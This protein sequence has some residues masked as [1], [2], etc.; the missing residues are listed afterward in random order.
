L[1]ENGG[2][3]LNQLF[4]K[5]TAGEIIGNLVV[6]IPR[7]ISN[8]E[9]KILFD[10]FEKSPEV[11]GVAIFEA[12]D[13]KGLV[14]RNHFYRE[15][16]K[17][18]G[19]ALYMGRPVAMLMDTAPMIVDYDT[20]MSK[21]GIMAM[22]RPK[23]NLYDHVL[24]KKDKQFVGAVGI[25]PLLSE[26]SRQSEE[27][28]MVLK[29]QNEALKK[30]NE[31]EI[32]LT[33]TILEKNSLLE[34]KSNSIKNLLD[35]AGQ[36]FL[37]FSSD[38]L[39]EEDYS[40][41]CE[42]IIERSLRNVSYLELISL[43]FEERMVAVQQ[44]ALQR[45]FDSSS[46]I[47]DEAYLSLLPNECEIGEKT[48]RLDYK[49]IEF[50]GEKKLMVV[51]T[52]ISEKVALERSMEEERQNQRLIVKALTNSGDINN[53]F[54]ELKEFFETGIRLTLANN[55]VGEEVFNEIFRQVH[56]FKG[57]FAQFGLHNTSGKLHIL[58]DKLQRL[59]ENKQQTRQ[60]ITE[61]LAGVTTEELLSKDKE[62]LTNILGEDFLQK[63][64]K[65]SVSPDAVTELA[66]LVQKVCPEDQC[67]AILPYINKLKCINMK[68]L[69]SQYEDY[70]RYLAERLA[71]PMPNFTV[72]G[73][74]VWIEKE[75]Y[76]N[77]FKSSVH[78]FRNICDHGIEYPEERAERQKNL[79]GNI[80]CHISDNGCGN[81]LIEISDD[82]QGIDPAVI[83][84][85]ALESGLF[86]EED[87]AHWREEEI[88]NLVFTQGF[89]TKSKVDTLS[90]RGVGMAAVK[91]AVEQL[92]G[93]I[94]LKSCPGIGTSYLI[95]IPK[96]REEVLV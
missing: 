20:E 15:I 52:D 94:S 28:V 83:R 66:A 39:I 18:F 73:D 38:F 33:K 25:S 92:N 42:K 51:L 85:K 17:Q 89:S 61:V 24:V 10:L 80:T 1:F 4:K 32:A 67:K 43:L 31:Q 45:Y 81:I 40:L 96:N 22:S 82:G 63:N 95:I 34:K 71:K 41:E 21:V 87:L 50:L 77:L 62:V 59:K 26:L 8:Q 44:M 9:G 79:R 7:M 23:N 14:M 58:E 3:K 12:E 37:S 93:R 48:I 16:A 78:L 75:D 86:K 69:L 76:S 65:L 27:Q 54:E 13:L 90:G 47:K 68:T 74:D 6:S 72:Y 19:H 46:K 29:S 30:A 5:E 49:P 91:E 88:I 36:G 64:N 57:D 60:A 55:Q 2:F 70:V 53:M 11:D 84:Q 35:H 56:T